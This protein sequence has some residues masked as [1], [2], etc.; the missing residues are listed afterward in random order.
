MG[1]QTD[2]NLKLKGAVVSRG[3]GVA[4]CTYEMPFLNAEYYKDDVIP[5]KDLASIQIQSEISV[6]LPTLIPEVNY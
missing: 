5:H 6:P 3:Y 1:I 2:L 4:T